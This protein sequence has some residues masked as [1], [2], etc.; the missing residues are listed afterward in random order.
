[1]DIETDYEWDE[2]KRQTNQSK[3]G[4]DFKIVVG[5]DWKT[6][7]IEE[8]RRFNY[9][10]IRYIA[11][12]LI[13]LTVYSFSFTYRGDIYALSISERRKSLR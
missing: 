8:N 9:S 11:T 7:Q 5:F 13:E 12:G 3:H 6:A 4:V 2:E 10:E 1:M